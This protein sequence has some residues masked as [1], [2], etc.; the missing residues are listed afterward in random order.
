MFDR[1]WHRWP[2][3]RPT[4][5]NFP[6]LLKINPWG[7]AALCAISESITKFISQY[8]HD[9]A[10]LYEVY[11]PHKYLSPFSLHPTEWTLGKPF[12]NIER[13]W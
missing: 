9:V 5:N 1:R 10:L 4:R 13:I 2:Q 6:P 8:C 11:D 3:K 7:N 12:V